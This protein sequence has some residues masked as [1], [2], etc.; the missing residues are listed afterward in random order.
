MIKVKLFP[1]K[2][3]G[4]VATKLILKETLIEVAP[5]GSFPAKQ[6]PL[7]NETEI[8]KYYFVIP[9]EYK[10]SK[11]NYRQVMSPKNK[12]FFVVINFKLHLKKNPF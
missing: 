7:I 9:A 1:K 10:N 6:R 2:G 12:L 4:I 3:R 5:V 11:N 8:S